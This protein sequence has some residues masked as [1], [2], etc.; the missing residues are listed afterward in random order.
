MASNHD[1]VEDYFSKPKYGAMTEYE[2]D[3]LVWEDVKRQE[4]EAARRRP[5]KEENAFSK[6]CFILAG[7]MALFCLL[8]PDLSTFF[9]SITF[10][11]LFLGVYRLITAD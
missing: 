3:Q 9:G 5:A 2:M 8:I 6:I 1:P 4:E 7:M 10:I 11:A